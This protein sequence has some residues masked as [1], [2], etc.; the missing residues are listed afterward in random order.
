LEKK[1]SQEDKEMCDEGITL[2]EI[3][4]KNIPTLYEPPLLGINYVW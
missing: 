3:S 1:L 4:L 2:D